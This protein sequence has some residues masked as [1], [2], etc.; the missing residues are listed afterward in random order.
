MVVSCEKMH[1]AFI[2]VPDEA[3]WHSNECHMHLNFFSRIT[4]TYIWDVQDLDNPALMN[5]YR[6]NVESIDHN[7]YIRGGYVYQSNYQV[8]LRILS[9]DQANYALTLVSI[10]TL[11]R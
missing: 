6:A 1:M 9:I 7:Q 2:L 11:F 5:T 3:I 8:G 4:K 10:I